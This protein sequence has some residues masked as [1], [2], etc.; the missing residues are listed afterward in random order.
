M[1]PSQCSSA[2]TQTCIITPPLSRPSLVSCRRYSD[3]SRTLQYQLSTARPF[4]ERSLALRDPV[5]RPLAAGTAALRVAP[6]DAAP[7]PRSVHGYRRIA[8]GLPEG[9][10]AAQAAH[11]VTHRLLARSRRR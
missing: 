4:C 7:V 5:P 3:R 6:Y 9:P 1:W 2:P 8:L 11:E 10:V